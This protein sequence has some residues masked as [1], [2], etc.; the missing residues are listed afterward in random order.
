MPANFQEIYQKIKEIGQG[1]RERRERIENLRKHARNLLEQN[2]DELDYLKRIVEI[3]KETDSNI[4]C[5][6]PLNESLTSHQEP[7]PAQ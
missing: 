7:K 3:V 2:A 5:A 1:A 6:L 4:R